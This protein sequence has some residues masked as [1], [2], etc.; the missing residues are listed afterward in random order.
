MMDK[1][2]TPPAPRS[3]PHASRPTL[4]LSTPG[5]QL[6][7][8]IALMTIVMVYHDNE[9]D[10]NRTY[11]AEP[12]LAILTKRFKTSHFAMNLAAAGVAVS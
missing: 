10:D 6:S 12:V 7:T 4:S 1:R 8:E 2:Q 9:H 11:D 5:S 3:T